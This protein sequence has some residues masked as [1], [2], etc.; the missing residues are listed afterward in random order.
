MLQKGY[1][2]ESKNADDRLYVL[3][4]TASIGT[5]LTLPPYLLRRKGVENIG[6]CVLCVIHVS[7]LN[8]N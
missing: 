4:E 5:L 1:A 6:A 3:I 7:V 8:N 2:V